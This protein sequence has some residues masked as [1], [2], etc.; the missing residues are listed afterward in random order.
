MRVLGTMVSS[1][2]GLQFAQFHTRPLQQAI[3]SSWNKTQSSL[4][5]TIAL[6]PQVR[7]ELQLQ[8]QVVAL[9]S[10]FGLWQILF[11]GLM[12]DH[13]HRCQPP[14]MERNLPTSDSPRQM[15]SVGIKTAHQHSGTS[16]H[17]S[18][19]ASLDSSPEVTAGPD[20]VRQCH[21]GSVHQPPGGNPQSGGDGGVGQNSKVGRGICT[22][23]IGS[24]HSRSG[25]LDGELPQR[26]DCGPRRV[27]SAHRGVRCHLSPLGTVG[28]G[29]DGIQDQPQASHLHLADK[30]SPGMR[31]RRTDGPM[32]R[33]F[34]SVR[35]PKNHFAP[36]VLKKWWLKNLFPS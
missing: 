24:L 25:E 13:Q 18:V 17:S 29:S 21:S 8:D 4:D 35:L 9:N 28:H 27:V 19:P 3:L 11:P 1:F 7:S 5:Y 22:S 2:E 14:Q 12:V 15:V 30:R 6:P 26:E 34:P 36:D 16:V 10:S 32:G 23:V 31:S 33:L 20:P